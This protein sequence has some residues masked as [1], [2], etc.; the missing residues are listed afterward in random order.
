MKRPTLFLLTALI[1]AMTAPA[2]VAQ[3]RY[4]AVVEVEIDAGSG[5]SDDLSY[6]E[7]REITAELRR[8]V[9]KNLPKGKYNG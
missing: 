6:A 1:A 2:A 4:V 9:V 3:L 7:A 8:E 5:A